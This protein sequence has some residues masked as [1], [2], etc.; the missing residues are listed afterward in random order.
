[1]YTAAKH[2]RY[3]LIAKHRRAC[4]VKKSAEAHLAI[5]S[6]KHSATVDRMRR[7]IAHGEAVGVATAVMAETLDDRF[8]VLERDDRIEQLLTELKSRR[9]I[10]G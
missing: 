4:A 2:C 10:S 3:L 5:A 9:Q 1:M 7:K 6:D 8:E